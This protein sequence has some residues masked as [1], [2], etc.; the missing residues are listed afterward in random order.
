MKWINFLRVKVTNSY[1]LYSRWWF[2][3]FLM[4]C[5]WKNKIEVFAFIYEITYYSNFENPFSTVCGLSIFPST[6][7]HPLFLDHGLVGV[8]SSVDP[9]LHGCSD[10]APKYTYHKRFSLWFY[11]IITDDFRS[12]FQGQKNATIGSLKRVTQV[13]QIAVCSCSVPSDVP[14]FFVQR[15]SVRR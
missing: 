5:C 13:R 7:S 2:Q 4:P 11:T 3:I 1:F 15:D 9:S 14:V 6:R 8:L 12:Y 10:N